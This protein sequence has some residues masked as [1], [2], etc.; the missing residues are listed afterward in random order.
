MFRVHFDAGRNLSEIFTWRKEKNT[1]VT[2][3]CSQ[4]SFSINSSQTGTI[5]GRH[6]GGGRVPKGSISCISF[7]ATQVMIVKHTVSLYVQIPYRLKTEA[8][9]VP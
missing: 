6:W 1:F 9:E 4:F 2:H 3:S 8:S 7:P 5:S